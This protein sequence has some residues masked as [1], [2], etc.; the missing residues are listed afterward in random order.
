MTPAPP[1]GPPR[2]ARWRAVAVYAGAV[3]ACL[4]GLT[5]ALRLW[6]ADLRVPFE[7]HSDSM[8]FAALAKGAVEQGWY[9][10]NGQVGAPFGLD[11]HDFP[12][13]DSLHF[14]AIKL[15][16]QP[17]W[18]FAV[19]YNLYFL[20]TFPLTT[21][22]ALYVLRR[23]HVADGPAV[24]GS[25]LFTFLPYHFL[26]GERHLF[27]ASY[28]LVPLI[29]RVIVQL[30]LGRTPFLRPDP[31]GGRIRFTLRDGR[32]AAAAL[33]CLLVACAGV[34]YAFFACY[35]LVVAGLAAAA[36]RRR[37]Y[38]LGAAGI[39]VAVIGLGV[40]ANLTPTFVY[41]GRH[42]GNPAAVVRDPG[43]AEEYGLKICQLFVPVPGH[44]LAWCRDLEA[45]YHQSAPLVNE[46]TSVALGAVGAV[47]FV[48]LV[49]R[50]LFRKPSFGRAA[51]AEI[52]ARL[53]LAAVLLAT[54]GGLGSVFSYLACSWIRA[55]NRIAVFIAF[56][57]LFAVALALDALRRR[58]DHSGRARAVFAGLLGLLL[59]LGILDQTSAA[60]VPAYARVRHEYAADAR[61]VRA[62]E[63]AV[64][65]H[66]MI[67]Q[68]PYLA[69]PESPAVCRME[70]YA[71]FRGFLHSRTLRWS[72]GALKGREGDLWLQQL[73]ARPVDRL[74][75]T[76][77]FAGFAGV[78]VDRF[79]Y[80]DL[81]ADLVRRL[82]R[83]LG[84]P[85]V[86]RA[87]GRYVFFD[88]AAYTRRLHAGCTASEWQARAGEAL[89]PI[90]CG[91][92]RGCY[93]PEDIEGHRGRWC[94]SEAELDVV[95]PTNRTRVVRLEMAFRAFRPEP[96]EVRIDGS[97][98]AARVPITGRTASFAREVTVPPGTSVIRFRCDAGK[99]EVPN[100]RRTLVFWVEDFKTETP[101]PSGSRPRG[102]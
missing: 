16:A 45:R 5:F 81:G 102:S 38:P 9:L 51:L 23:F 62:I 54:S 14:L 18:S 15:L 34:Y 66:A 7:Y 70:D 73:A 43:Q 30:G 79:G 68:L 21:L 89:H 100:E 8:L 65:S 52:L 86:V 33:V 44:R 13:V 80:A 59:G 49:A 60:F 85:A 91:W 94:S 24:V 41:Q 82:A 50:L 95:N 1:T 37:L 28:Y 36:G 67:F 58:C 3:A 77:A 53:T 69:F 83:R 42:G 39:A 88:L 27:L 55:Y 20:L 40:L 10:H 11:M 72:Y 64:P 6:R 17:G 29:V 56:F 98:F 75:E 101:R 74:V 32:S 22:S 47:G 19:A 25:L 84:K 4:L 48:L 46:N 90:L 26:R 76:L 97:G 99:L 12:L 63:A 31:E 93:P 35:F 71:P 57:A 92:F 78:S 2:P 61:Y 87:D 96:I